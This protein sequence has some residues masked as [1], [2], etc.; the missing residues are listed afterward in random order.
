MLL[1]TALLLSALAA[2]GIVSAA[3][4][5]SGHPVV[6]DLSKL[7]SA[8]VHAELL[9]NAS[10]YTGLEPG[11]PG[12]R[13][14]LA[15]S[16]TDSENFINFCKGRTTTNGKQNTNG[17]CSPIPLG[18]I[19]STAQMPSAII[20][21]PGHGERLPANTTVDVVVAVRK[22]DA[23]YLVNPVASYY[24]APQDL[25]AQGRIKGHLH[26]VVQRLAAGYG[27]RVPPD[28]LDFAYFKGLDDPLDEQGELHAQVPGGLPVGIYRLC[29][30]MS[31]RN[32]QPVVMPVANRGAQDDCVRFE[33]VERVS[34]CAK[35]AS[36]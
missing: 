34:R 12:I 11:T 10:R 3:V 18:R 9:Q 21:K 27:A 20:W 35:R 16:E 5:V 23:G 13:E 15:P 22:L 6:G 28:P 32:H 25:D 24:T 30:M 33:V 17:S 36:R 8:C 26:I 1:P 4:A 14:G 31:S 29:T 7:H 2:A 19:P